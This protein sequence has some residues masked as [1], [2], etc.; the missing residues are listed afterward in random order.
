MSGPTTV[1]VGVDPITLLLSAA[2]I[3]AAQALA[4]G[5]EHAAD[6]RAHHRR[7]RQATLRAVRDAR[8]QGQAALQQALQRAEQRFSQL[9]GVAESIGLGER[10]RAM[11]PDRPALPDAE[12]TARYVQ[13]LETLTQ[14]LRSIVLGAVAERREALER[15]ALDTQEAAASDVPAQALGATPAASLT[16]TLHQTREG[17]EDAAQGGVGQAP[18]LPAGQR[19]LA[20]LAHLAEEPDLS[21]LPAELTSLARTLDLTPPGERADLLATE[22]RRQVQAH[23]DAVQARQVQEA[24]ATVV[25]QCLEDLGYE[26]EGIGETLFVEGGVTHFRRPGWGDHMVRMRVAEGGAQA[27]FN[28]VRAVDTATDEPSAQDAIAEDRWCTEFPALMHALA[29][30]GVQ[31]EVTRRLEAGE[32]PVQRVQRDKLPRFADEE[33]RP[34]IA[35]PLARPLG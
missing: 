5:L 35:A 30:R 24:T 26:V 28:V 14:E 34:N 8:A 2:A 23:L 1:L 7:D 12:S 29:A 10:L 16:Q 32:L 6:E 21:D 33:A 18:K 20:R 27:N 19:L 22:L 4:Q 3:H 11:Q 17:G 25:A 9:V 31:L 15:T 13:S